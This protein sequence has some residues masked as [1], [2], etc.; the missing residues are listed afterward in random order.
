MNIEV[1]AK[2]NYIYESFTLL[3]SL[4]MPDGHPDRLIECRKNAQRLVHSQALNDRFQVVDK[5]LKEGA[6]ALKK[7]MDSVRR[8]FS[9][10]PQ[11]QL[12]L[13]DAILIF[14][15]H[16][17][18]E[19]AAELENFIHSQGI[20]ER[21]LR[22]INHHE[23]SFSPEE[24]KADFDNISAV[25]NIRQWIEQSPLS[26]G[27]K[28]E[29]FSAFIHHEKHSKAI[30]Q[31]IKKAE[32]VLIKTKELWSPI[33]DG[34]YE[35][36]TLQSAQRDI[37]GD[38]KSI[39]HFDL[40]KNRPDTPI[41]L[42]PLLLNMNMISFCLTDEVKKADYD[43]YAIGIFY[44]E[45]VYLDFNRNKN[46]DIHQ[47]AALQILK[48]LSDKSKFDI[49]SSIKE[50]PA[51]GAQLA[52][53]MNLTTATISYHMSALIQERLIELDR[54]NNRIYYRMNKKTVSDF[55]EYLKKELL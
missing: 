44:G 6:S 49:L 41:C 45:N 7:D 23:P 53:Q 21:C 12:C 24:K 15:F 32:G 52:R 34:F 10:Y 2:I 54:T 48:L 18:I 22:F 16:D 50:H 3:Q 17:P 35:Y 11:S 13:A 28:W 42:V 8:Y 33:I 43:V 26:P 25:E 30:I 14:D 20:E 31:L 46:D 5:I 36:W 1:I 51:Y 39:F 37:I 47:A 9:C 29:F 38:I 55:I 27:D 4:T 19:R 40:Q